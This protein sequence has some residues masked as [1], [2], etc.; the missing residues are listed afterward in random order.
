MVRHI[1]RLTPAHRESTLRTFCLEVIIRL[2]PHT[3]GNNVPIFC[4]VDY[5]QSITPI[6]GDPALTNS[7]PTHRSWLHPVH[8]ESTYMHLQ[9]ILSYGWL[10]P[11]TRGIGASHVFFNVFNMASSPSTGNRLIL[12]V[13]SDG[14]YGITPVHGEVTRS[15]DFFLILGLASPPY[16]GN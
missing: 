2:H 3:R 9:K 10:H 14:L 8:G 12:T 5:Q 11:R 16:T 6:H 15:S 4:S 13:A 7:A 1:L